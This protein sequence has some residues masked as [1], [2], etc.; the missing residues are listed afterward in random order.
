[1][2]KK[3]CIK[4]IQSAQDKY[5]TFLDNVTLSILTLCY[6]DLTGHTQTNTHTKLLYSKSLCKK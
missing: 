1:M 6:R 4:S 2:I 3:N 5:K